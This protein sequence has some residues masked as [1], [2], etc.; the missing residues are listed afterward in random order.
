MRSGL[1]VVV[2]QESRES[3]GQDPVDA[4]RQRVVRAIQRER[5]KGLDYRGRRYRLVLDS[6]LHRLADRDSFEVV[7]RRDAVE[8]LRGLAAAGQAG[9]GLAQR[10]TEAAALLTPDWRPPAI[11]DGLV[12]L[13]RIVVQQATGPDLG[14]T[15][16]PSQLKKLGETPS[17]T[18]I[19]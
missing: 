10:L 7:S 3:D 17:T 4:E 1:L 9:A 11:P 8:V 18:T 5:A 15:L 13:C 12:L 19:R 16:T 6:Q 2:R 14:P